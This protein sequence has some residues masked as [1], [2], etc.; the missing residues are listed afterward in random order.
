M[1]MHTRHCIRQAR[2]GHGRQAHRTPPKAVS[3]CATSLFGRQAPRIV[4]ASGR[5]PP[6]LGF[7]SVRTALA[8][9]T[10][11]NSFLSHR[12]TFT[13]TLTLTHTHTSLPN[14]PRFLHGASLSWSHLATLHSA[15]PPPP[16]RP[17]PPSSSS[18]FPFS[19]II[20]S[21]SITEPS[22]VCCGRRPPQLN[23]LNWLIN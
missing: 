23:W 12:H 16:P 22:F 2:G 21:C 14:R 13:L 18:P 1:R 15:C 4:V 5:L 10:H 11:T 9:H 19:P 8:A 3:S 20:S 6:F 7:A 17:P